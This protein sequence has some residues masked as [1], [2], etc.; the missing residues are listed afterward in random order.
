MRETCA[1]VRGSCAGV[2][3]K[4]VEIAQKLRGLL[5]HVVEGGL[6]GLRGGLEKR[7]ISERG[8]LRATGL[9]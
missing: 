5:L 6:N 2:A 3:S 4:C 8:A 1:E 9:G 7:R